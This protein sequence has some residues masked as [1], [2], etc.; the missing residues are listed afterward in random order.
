MH[1]FRQ[2]LSCGAII[3]TTIFLVPSDKFHWEFCRLYMSVVV[4]YYCKLFKIQPYEYH[5]L[6]HNECHNKLCRM[7]ECRLTGAN[8]FFSFACRMYFWF[9]ILPNSFTF[10]FTRNLFNF[11]VSSH[12]SNWMNFHNIIKWSVSYFL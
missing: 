5:I 6:Y 2:I 7:K 11:F 8:F 9:I 12:W 1:W 3:E 10:C 4:N